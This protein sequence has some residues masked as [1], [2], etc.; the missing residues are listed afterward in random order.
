MPRVRLNGVDLDYEAQGIGVPV[1]FSHGGHS[2]LRYWEP[3][4]E[5]FAEQYRFVTYTRR[6]HGRREW[7][8][9]GDNSVEAHVADLV[10]LLRS[11]DAGP[12]HLVGFSTNLAL[13]AAL[14]EPAVIRSL[15]VI[16]PNVPWLLEGDPEGEAVLAE[17]RR[18]TQRIDGEAGGD[19]AVAA[20]L[21][22]ELVNNRGQ[23]AF[24]AQPTALRDMW[25]DNFG[26]KRPASSVPEPLTCEVLRLITAPTLLLEAEFGMPYSRRIAAALA[27]CVPRCRRRVMTGVTHF[28]SYQSPAAF[29]SVVL[30]FLAEH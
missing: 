10:A 24:E 29:N 28:M 15:T 12:V 25:L 30:D 8:A 14:A 1:V 18:E 19:A 26:T 4:R 21:W 6:F 27:G 11:L 17:W 3:Q 16:E 20:G 22:F 13:R 9:R 5:A 2:D 23:G 7:P